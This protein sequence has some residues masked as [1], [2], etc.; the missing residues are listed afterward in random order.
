MNIY[1]SGIGGVGLGPLAEIVLDAGHTVLGS[2]PKESLMTRQMSE[3]GVTISTDQSGA[4][5]KNEHAKQPI[6]WFVYTSALSADHPELLAAKE[7]G[8]KTSKR[9]ELLATIIKEKGLKLIAVAGTHGKTTTT[10]LFVWVFQQL[11]IPTSYSVGTTMSFGPSGKFDPA[12]EYF[13]YESDEYDR[14]FLQFHPYLAIIPSLSYDHPDTYLTEQE[15]IAA[16]RE[17]LGQSEGSIFWKETGEK[18]GNITNAW[19]LGQDDVADVQLPGEHV[20]RNASLVVKAFER[21][22]IGG[23]IVGAINQ[24]PGVDRRF[25]K[26]AENLYTDYAVHPN[27]IAATIKLAREVND[28]VVVVYQPHQNARQHLIKDLYTKETFENASEVYW[29]PTYLTRENPD[30]PT[31]T[32]QELAKNVANV[33]FAELDDHLWEIIQQ[34]RDRGA[35]VLIMGAG[36]ID[37]WVRSLLAIHHGAGVLLIEGEGNIILQKRD[38]KSGISHPGKLAAFAGGVEPF[39]KSLHDAA[40]R[41]L[42]EETNLAFD[43][44]T[45]KYLGLIKMEQENGQPAYT[46]YYIL[47][48]VTTKNLEVYEGQGFELVNPHKLD[49]YP[50]TPRVRAAI[51]MYL[52]KARSLF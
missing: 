37:G 30:Q 11:G 47:K 1:F 45:L 46:A 41:E 21:L 14:N 42:K 26:L 49:S 43:P 3:R 28:D 12:S 52:K 35:L 34:A 31:L 7:L 19:M 15:Y 17:F 32:P 9:D 8:I 38:N 29:I 5:L 44:N 40:V 25:E 24:F 48:P 27:E 36:P 10:S 4:F 50:L 23:D 39:D 18:V 22:G 33:H 2:D 51:T 6:D 13:V 16:F 20:R